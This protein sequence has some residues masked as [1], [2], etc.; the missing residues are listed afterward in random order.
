VTRAL[1]AG[2]VVLLLAGC[3][4]GEAPTSSVRTLDRT[5]RVEVVKSVGAE[6]GFDPEEIYERDGPGVVTVIA[7]GT[8]SGSGGGLGSGFVVSERGEI[9][10]N[11]HVVTSG[12]GARLRNAD[13]LYVS[14]A[15]GDQVPARIVG[16]DPFSDVAL[17]RVDPAGLT[18]RP[19]PFASLTDLAVGSPVAAIG[20]P[21]G[22]D[23]SL[24]V[25]VVSA[26][27]R[28]IESL[29]GFDI[30][31]AIQTDAAINSGNSGGPLLNAAGEVLG[32]N[33]QIRTRS[34]D[35]SGVGFAVPVDVVRRS[36]DQLRKSGRVRYPYLGVSTRGVYRQLAERFDLPVNEGAWVQEIVRGGPAD[37]AG[38]R[39]GERRE[40]FQEAG[41][42]V[43]GDVITK[44]AGHVLKR[45]TDLGRALLDFSPGQ[46]VELEVWRDGKKRTVAV[47]LGT[48]PLAAPR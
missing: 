22:E 42:A 32:I 47:Q 3:G 17:L 29:T 8:S 34:G 4:G 6:Q 23:R 16:T 28:S 36:L 1:L 33:S 18:L 13:H 11:A 48:R 44:L 38:L 12:T 45:D 46:R 31:G 21:F 35:G 43:G 7:V 25:G 20:S 9:A 2:I 5:T 26:T 39:A 15:S 37:D 19:L 14:F 41:W 27:D 24:S 40:R 30:S 10:T